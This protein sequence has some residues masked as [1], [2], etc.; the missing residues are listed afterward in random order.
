MHGPGATGT[1][2]QMGLTAVLEIGDI[3][4]VL[5]SLPSLEWDPAVYTSVGL[6]PIDAALI[7]VKSPGHFRA[8]YSPLASQVLVADTPGAA[9]PNMRTLALHKVTRP[10]YPLDEI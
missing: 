10:L 6:D 3:R 9:R 8:A 4:L 2:M 1:L 7:F 5:K